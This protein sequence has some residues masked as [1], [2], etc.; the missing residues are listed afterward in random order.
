MNKNKFILLITLA[1]TVFWSL[2]A[3]AVGALEHWDDAAR[4]ALPLHIKLWLGAM[5]LCNISALFFVK[6]HKAA[7]WVF[8]GFFFSHVLVI[9]GFW[10]TN[11]PVLAGQVSLFHIIF[12]TPGVYMLWRYRDEIKG[13]KPYAIWAPLSALFYIGSMS[14][15]IKDA[16]LYILHALAT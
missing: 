3:H 16:A 9:L 5:L 1:L 4:H 14:I 12:W 2:D 13:L 11:T 7:R 8:G 6:N 10:G 15:D